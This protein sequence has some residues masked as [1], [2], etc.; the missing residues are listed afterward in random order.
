MSY[1]LSRK[2][3]DSNYIELTPSQTVVVAEQLSHAKNLRVPVGDLSLQSIVQV[4]VTKLKEVKKGPIITA[5]N[6]FKRR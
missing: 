4:A 2:I 1:L 5:D 3:V 6:A